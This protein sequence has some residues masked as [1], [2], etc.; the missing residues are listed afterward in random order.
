MQPSSNRPRI[1]V[2]MKSMRVRIWKTIASLAVSTLGPP[3]CAT[4]NTPR[5]SSVEIDAQRQ[6]R[7][8]FLH[9][10]RKLS[11]FR[12]TWKRSIDLPRVILSRSHWP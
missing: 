4:F 11:A 1:R 3:S 9:A 12:M 7:V 6:D 8:V 5:G 10:R 2:L